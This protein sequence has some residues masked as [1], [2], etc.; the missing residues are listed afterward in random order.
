DEITVPDM[1]VLL[2]ALGE[3]FET[4]LLKHVGKPWVVRVVDFDN[5]RAGWRVLTKPLV[6]RRLL[7]FWVPGQPDLGAM[8]ANSRHDLEPGRFADWLRFVDPENMNLRFRLDAVEVVTEADE[9]ERDPP[10]ARSDVL[11]ADVV[12]LGQPRLGDD[13]RLDLGH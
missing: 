4:L 3:V 7:Q 8:L 10:V 5:L 1:R 11:L 13:C 12:A 2:R 9:R 6:R